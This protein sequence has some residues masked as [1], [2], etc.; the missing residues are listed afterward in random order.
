M[1]NACL[2]Q[3]DSR[4][5]LFVGFMQAEKAIGEREILTFLARELEPYKVPDAVEVLEDFPVSSNG[6][7][8]RKAIEAAYS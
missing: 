4:L 5:V 2:I 8:N 1:I 3:A 6:K 7:I